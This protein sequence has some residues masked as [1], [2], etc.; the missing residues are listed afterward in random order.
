MWKYH[1]EREGDRVKGKDRVTEEKE[2]IERMKESARKRGR[3]DDSVC[4]CV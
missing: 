2:L 4:V 3:E 1:K